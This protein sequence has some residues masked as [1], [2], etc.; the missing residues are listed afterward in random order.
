MGIQD[1]SATS[2]ISSVAYLHNSPIRP[3]GHNNRLLILKGHSPNRF[4][5]RAQLSHQLARLQVPDLDSPIAAAG[6]D[7]RVVELQAR[8]AVVVG[9][10]SV[11]GRL[12]LE[13]PD[14]H[15]AVGAAGDEDVAAHLELADEQGV[16][17]ED[18]FALSV[19]MV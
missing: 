18:G 10:E 14:P 11:D 9:R 7:A 15:G 19:E 1:K 6:H 8:D 5:R 13:R 17:L 12:L 2:A 16:A 3:T 4:G